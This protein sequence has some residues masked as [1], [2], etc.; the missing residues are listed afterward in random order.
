MPAPRVSQIERCDGKRVIDVR[1]NAIEQ[2]AGAAIVAELKDWIAT[3]NIPGSVEIRFEGADEDAAEA[4]AFFVGAA[5]AALF[6]MAVILLWEFDNFW[7]VILTLTAV[8]ISTAGV[9]VGVQLMLPYI[10]VLM[11]GTGV[12][13]LAGIVVNN[14]IVLIDTY[15]RL[16][17]DGRSPEYAAIATAAQ[18]IRPILLTTGTTICGL[19]PM[20]FQLK[21]DFAHGAINFGS[22]SSEWWVQLATAVV[23]GLAFS[24]IMILLVTPVWLL[25][26]Y[27][28]GRWM[29]R[30]RDRAL[31]R[32]P[33]DAVQVRS[34]DHKQEDRDRILPAAE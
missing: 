19:L 34:D 7:Q 26:P 27:R 17:S 8:I 28:V 14:N 31:P 6:M 22:A 25:V 13:A 10:S 32:K 18:R 16:R 9:L 3:Q 1:A 23:F 2:G 5:L 21:V 4:G 12:V 15:N 11:I 30:M 33:A 24:T 20:V 29:R